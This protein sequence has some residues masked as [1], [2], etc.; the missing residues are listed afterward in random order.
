[1]SSSFLQL[2]SLI[3]DAK[4]ALL[5]LFERLG[6]V[7]TRGALPNEV[8]QELKKSSLQPSPESLSDPEKDMLK[9]EQLSDIY[10]K[11]QKMDLGL[12]GIDPPKGLL[13]ELRDYQRIALEFMLKKET[14]GEIEDTSSLSPLWLEYTSVEG[15]PFYFNPFS[16]QLTRDFPKEEHCAGGILAGIYMR[17]FSYLA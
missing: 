15:V 3:R 6:L 16:G 2:D 12:Q 10:S 5:L 14:S 17:V 13:L 9:T 4:M 7:P 1:M 11:A 8:L